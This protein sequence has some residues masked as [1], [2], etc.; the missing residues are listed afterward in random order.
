MLN[1]L[2]GHCACG[3]V[4]VSI[5]L[6]KELSLY[7]PRACDCDFCTSRGAEYLSDPGGKIRLTSH[8]SLVEQQQGDNLAKFLTC[9]NCS[10]V[11]VAALIDDSNS[12]GA[13]NAT[14]LQGREKFKAS[15]SASPKLLSADEKV[16]RWTQ[17]WSPL[18]L[19]KP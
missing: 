3:Q 4:E 19:I 15:R 2:T 5:E 17:L 9:P 11:L 8:S 18:E 6:T 13:V 7:S 10:T 1:M 12:F 16:E 14:L